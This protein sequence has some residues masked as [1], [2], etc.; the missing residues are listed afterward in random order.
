M[1]EFKCC[2]RIFVTIASAL[3]WCLAY[4]MIVYCQQNYV[5]RV[6]ARQ[7][8]SATHRHCDIA[9]RILAGLRH[10]ILGK[11]SW[12]LER[13]IRQCTETNSR[14]EYVCRRENQ[15]S[16]CHTFQNRLDGIQSE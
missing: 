15:N 3:L 13:T 6:S 1:N 16:R 8:R 2:R 9:D 14:F 7:I 12:T 10:W 5:R 4:Q 11:C